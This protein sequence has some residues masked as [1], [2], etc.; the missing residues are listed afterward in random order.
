MGWDAIRWD[1]MGSDGNVWY[2]MI[3]MVWFGMA[4]C[5]IPGISMIW[6]GVMRYR[7]R[8]PRVKAREQSGL[9]GTY[10]KN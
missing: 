7:R 9:D 1:G 10:N 6:N 4:C 5:G 3:I 8:R 2:D